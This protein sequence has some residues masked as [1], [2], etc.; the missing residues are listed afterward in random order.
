MNKKN[1]FIT[2]MFRSGTTLIARM[3]NSHGAICMASDPFAPVFKCFRNEIALKYIN[4]E[5]DLNSPLHDYSSKR[6]FLE[7]GDLIQRIDF[8]LE[9]DKYNIHD[10]RKLVETH[11]KPYS[12]LIIP[13]LSEMKGNNYAELLNSGIGIVE[14]AYGSGNEE[15]IGI[16][17][18]WTNEFTPH[19]IK[20]FDESKVIIVIRDPRAVIASSYALK[21]Y[22]YPFLFLCRQWN[23]LTKAAID[24][25]NFYKNQ[26]ILVR[27]E[28][29][30]SNPNASI[31][32]ICEFLNINLD[33]NLLEISNFKDG[34]NNKWQQNSSYEE[35]KEEFNVNS[36]DK[37]SQKLTLEHIK[38]IESMCNE[39]MDCMN[40]KIVNQMSISSKVDALKSFVEI[41]D[42]LAEW[43][44]NYTNL[45]WQLEISEEIDKIKK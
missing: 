8:D 37:W 15:Y 3:L 13:Y 35:I 4:P 21:G 20:T 25:S 27:Y 19:F 42:G 10:I 36:L 41:D 17:E 30:I 32:S 34:S 28:D 6:F 39:L 24:Y 14:Q 7:L 29:L 16:K 5:F 2:G 33:K 9:L 26:V 1:I 40:Y 45:D 43:I 18:V 11:C 31:K 23:K 12:P 38:F 22:R 44:K